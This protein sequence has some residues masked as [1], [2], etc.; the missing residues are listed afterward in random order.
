MIRTWARTARMSLLAWLVCLALLVAATSASIAD[1][2]SAP[3]ARAGY[4][5]AIDQAPIVAAIS[6]SGTG[7][8]TLGGIIANELAIILF[9]GLAL[10]GILIS[11][12]LTRQNEDLGRIELLSSRPIARSTPLAS[13]MVV[14]TLFMVAVS[15]AI[16]VIMAGFGVPLTED[17]A[18]GLI[19]YCA[20]VCSYGLVWAGFGYLWGELCSDTRTA[21]MVALGIY[22]AAYLTRIATIASGTDLWWA[23]PLGWFDRVEPFEA[24]RLAPLIISLVVAAVLH[25][26]AIIIRSRR[27]IGTGIIAARPGPAR[28]S[29]FL[30]SL[31]GLL[32]RLSRATIIMWVLLAL[33][34]GVMF[35]SLLP[36]WIRIMELNL[37]SMEAFGFTA[38][39]D[40]ISQ[41][42]GIVASLFGGACGITIIGALGSEEKQSRLA[43]LLSRHVSRPAIWRWSISL[44]LLASLAIATL[45][46]ASYALSAHVA[47]VAFDLGGMLTSMSAYLIP[48]L[49]LV[50]VAVAGLSLRPGGHLVG[51]FYYAFT[52]V[53]VFMGEMMK[54]PTWLMNL[55]P[56][57]A[58]G[59]VP[60][61][62]AD[63][64][65]LAIQSVAAL[66]LIG[67]SPMAFS[68]RE[69]TSA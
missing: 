65:A 26:L 9:T 62:A 34:L 43:Y 38:N 55:S 17:H 68:R 51:W 67:I 59:Q 47:D 8:T 36:D 50:A 15:L 33:S 23:T 46:I 48:T 14:T 31:P 52:A 35:G 32:L 41:I 29:R 16:G 2:Y 24:S 3:A 10:A 5:A 13:A 56:L 45:T 18:G 44:A 40:S 61:T 28:A 7:L 60:V 6:G 54:A 64:T 12:G 27:D 11:T 1:F 69:L 22:A 25:G 58:L 63:G 57:N 53:M 19:L 39:A 4:A 49:L 20:S 37:D 30:A 42:I 66:V 21:R